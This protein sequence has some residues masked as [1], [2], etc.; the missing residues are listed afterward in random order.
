MS[1]ANQ[2]TM[3]YRVAV[4]NQNGQI[5]HQ[6][7]SVPMTME[8][9]VARQ[10]TMRLRMAVSYFSSN[11]EVLTIG[12]ELIWASIVVCQPM[13]IPDDMLVIANQIQSEQGLLK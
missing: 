1:T 5:V 10:T 6:I 11:G 9:L 2:N 12:P 8:E 13:A 4:I 3:L 7:E